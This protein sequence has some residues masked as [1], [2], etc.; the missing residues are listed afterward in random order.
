MITSITTEAIAFFT[1]QSAA[2]LPAMIFTAG[3]LRGQGLS[4][5]EVGRYQAALKK[6]MEFWVTLLFLD[7]AAV[8]L[9][10][11][12]KAA[13][14][15]WKVSF[16]GYGANMAFVLI[17]C[18]CLSGV[19]ALLRMVPFVRGVMSLLELNGLFVRK[20]LEAEATKVPPET[21]SPSPAKPMALPEGYGKI[22][23]HARK[24]RK[25]T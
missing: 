18:T 4:L 16:E 19:L 24:R 11:I 14:W 22:L 7:L 8:M 10:I 15:K 25:T 6:Q 1:I 12:G 3:L 17:F 5:V 9:L 13:D 20:A 21:R 2:I 23:P